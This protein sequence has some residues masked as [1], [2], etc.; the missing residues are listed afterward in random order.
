AQPPLR[1]PQP[2]LHRRRALALLRA[3]RGHRVPQLRPALGAHHTRPLERISRQALHRHAAFPRQLLRT[4]HLHLPP[5]QRAALIL[6]MTLMQRKRASYLV[7]ALTALW[8][9]VLVVS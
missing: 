7:F 6:T 4:A 2:R 3:G 8:L 1:F 5:P 9:A